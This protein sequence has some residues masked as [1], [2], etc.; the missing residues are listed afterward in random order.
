MSVLIMKESHKEACAAEYAL[1]HSKDNSSSIWKSKH[2]T[3]QV[4]S[5]TSK[6]RSPRLLPPRSQRILRIQLRFRCRR[7]SH[8]LPILINI[9]SVFLLCHVRR[10]CIALLSAYNIKLLLLITVVIL[11]SAIRDLRVVYLSISRHLILLNPL[12]GYLCRG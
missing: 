2:T 12:R 4:R 1:Q 9:R 7:R 5:L 8:R 10:I 3:S 6:A 11:R